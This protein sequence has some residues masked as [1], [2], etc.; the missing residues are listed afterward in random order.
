MEIASIVAAAR[1]IRWERGGSTC[2]CLSSVLYNA[3]TCDPN[4]SYRSAHLAPVHDED[5]L[6]ESFDGKAYEAQRADV[7]RIFGLGVVMLASALHS[8]GTVVTSSGGKKAVARYTAYWE[9][10][11]ECTIASEVHA[12]VPLRT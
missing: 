6:P 2:H 8:E 3:S 12:I 5:A 7:I 10:S 4:L 1:L 11:V 9:Q